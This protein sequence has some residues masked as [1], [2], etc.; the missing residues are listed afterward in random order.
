MK[1]NTKINQSKARV[2]S[3]LALITN[4]IIILFISLFFDISW[5][6]KVI[7]VITIFFV[8]STLIEYWNIKRLTKHKDKSSERDSKDSG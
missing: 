1:I 2:K 4:L 3:G 7:A 6:S 5:F 8:L